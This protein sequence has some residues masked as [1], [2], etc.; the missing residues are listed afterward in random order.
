MLSKILKN[1]LILCHISAISRIYR[2]QNEINKVKVK[3]L[4]YFLNV[5]TLATLLKPNMEGKEKWVR[6]K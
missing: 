2:M 3:F 4:S 5:K 1:K 6:F